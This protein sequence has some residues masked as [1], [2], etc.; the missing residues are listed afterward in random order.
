M[1]ART[2]TVGAVMSARIWLQQDAIAAPASPETLAMWRRVQEYALF[3]WNRATMPSQEILRLAGLGQAFGLREAH[4]ALLVPMRD[5]MGELWSVQHLPPRFR[6]GAGDT[7]PVPTFE[8]HARLQGL[9]HWIGQV[10]EGE[11]AGQC[12][13]IA[14]HLADAVTWH[15]ETGT[16]AVVAFA[17]DNLAALA[18]LLR[19]SFPLARIGLWSRW[20]EQ[21]PAVR[22]AAALAGVQAVA[23]CEA[24]AELRELGA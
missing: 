19:E 11:G 23:D 20:P 4:G 18:G 21:A 12:I 13:G 8:L 22:T 5:A 6:P 16:P 17:P 1:V 7:Y 9:H 10:P 14:E 2:G 15:R 3:Q 24:F